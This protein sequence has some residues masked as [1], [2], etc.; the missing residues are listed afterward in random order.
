MLVV[1][2]RASAVL[3]TSDTELNWCYHVH[4]LQFFHEETYRKLFSLLFVLPGCDKLL[5]PAVKF[6]GF[7][8][9]YG[10]LVLK[11]V[12]NHYF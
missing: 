3:H 8:P 6:H 12:L 9:L 4:I 11:V 5:G 2:E 10:E 1:A 7:K